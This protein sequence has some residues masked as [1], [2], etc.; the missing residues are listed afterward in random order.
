MGAGGGLD[1]ER[2]RGCS[3]GD[4]RLMGRG[5]TGPGR[6]GVWVIFSEAV[7]SLQRLPLRSLE[8]SDNS[9]VG[10]TSRGGRPSSCHAPRGAAAELA[11]DACARLSVYCLR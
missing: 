1:S 5:A 8:A 7:D 4:M 3:G 11:A 2:A 6:G 10:S 9:I